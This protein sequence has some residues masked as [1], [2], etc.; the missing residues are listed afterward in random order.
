MKHLLSLLLVF[1]PCFLFAQFGVSFH[2]SNLPFVG[3]NYETKSRLRPELRIGTDTYFEAISVEGI[4]SYD[5]INN[6]DYELYAGLGGR[7]NGFA[8]LVI[9]VGLNIYPL[10][11][12]QIG[13][14]I[15]L[16]PI[17][18]DANLLRGSWGIRYRFKK[19]TG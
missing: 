14:H 8:G 13:V 15:E 6:D 2:Q 1:F 7:L 11:A 10:P 16:A 3:L 9:P 5:L 18:G 19:K 17:I 4:V 12:K